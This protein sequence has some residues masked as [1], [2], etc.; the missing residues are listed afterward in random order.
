MLTHISVSAVVVVTIL[1]TNSTML[2]YW[3]IHMNQSSQVP[4]F[5][6]LGVTQCPQDAN[7]VFVPCLTLSLLI[8][9]L[10]I[11]SGGFLWPYPF[12]VASVSYPVFS[13]CWS[14]WAAL[15]VVLLADSGFVGSDTGPR[16]CI[17]EG[18]AY[19]GPLYAAYPESRLWKARLEGN[20]CL[21][22]FPELPQCCSWAPV[23][24]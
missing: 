21:C 19:R 6:G 17:S 24:G 15:G 22:G 3:G 13:Q 23:L 12:L 7:C 14:V 1:L 5:T 20:M 10:H 16:Y 2:T 4:V 11:N 9:D 8:W 18:A